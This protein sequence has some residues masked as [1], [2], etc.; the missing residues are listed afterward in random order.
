MTIKGCQDDHGYSDGDDGIHS[1]DRN[2]N[3]GNIKQS[4][5]ATFSR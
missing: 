4:F 2:G 1:G 5:T 3:D